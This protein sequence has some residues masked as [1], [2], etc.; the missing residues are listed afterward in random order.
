M[1][2]K[3]PDKRATITLPITAKVK[4]LVSGIMRRKT[5]PVTHVVQRQRDDSLLA[6]LSMHFRRPYATMWST[7]IIEA[8]MKRPQ[9]QGK[10]FAMAFEACGM[11]EA[12]YK[13]VPTTYTYTKPL[14]EALLWGR[15]ALVRVPKMGDEEGSQI[16]YWDGSVVHDPSELKAYRSLSQ[17][18]NCDLV[19]L[20]KTM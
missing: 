6:C 9:S 17:L 19:Y 14:L 1:S 3:T 7:E 11:T 15:P 18:G 2:S 8:F 13:S 20:L 10:L 5:P 4:A 12:D 16:V